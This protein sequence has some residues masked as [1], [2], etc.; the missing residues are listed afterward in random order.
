MFL[1]YD[2]IRLWFIFLIFQDLY[3]I[4]LTIST[5]KRMSESPGNHYVVL[6]QHQANLCPI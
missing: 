6:D 4:I 5:D 2:A 3:T 1:K